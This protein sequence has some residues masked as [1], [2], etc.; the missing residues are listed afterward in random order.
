M[1]AGAYKEAGVPLEGVKVQI[2]GD[3]LTRERFS[4][5]KRLRINGTD[6]AEQLKH[7]SPIS[8][9]LFHLLMNF[10][11]MIFSTLYSEDM[12]GDLCTMQCEKVSIFLKEDG[13]RM[14]IQMTFSVLLSTKPPFSI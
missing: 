7:L 2:G 5:A 4:G 8:F 13:L 9:E 10:L 1:L 14:S 11:S 3:Q 6:D 12:S